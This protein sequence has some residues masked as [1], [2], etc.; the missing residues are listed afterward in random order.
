MRVAL[1]RDVRSAC[2]CVVSLVV[3]FC[4]TQVAVSNLEQAASEKARLE[5]LEAAQVDAVSISMDV[6]VT[7]CFLSIGRFATSMAHP[8]LAHS[9]LLCCRLQPLFTPALAQPNAVP[10]DIWQRL[11]KAI[12]SIIC[13]GGL[14]ETI[15]A[16]DAMT[17]LSSASPSSHAFVAADAIEVSLLCI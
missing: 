14:Q 5:A 15:S 8:V 11:A 9:F 17:S 1:S 13:D 16:A 10:V 6:S 3:P 12:V 2:L 7:F 4:C